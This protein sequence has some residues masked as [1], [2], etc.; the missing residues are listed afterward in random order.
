MENKKKDNLEQIASPSSL[1]GAD[2]GCRTSLR[3]K[4][5][6]SRIAPLV[7]EKILPKVIRWIKDGGGDD[8]QETVRG[9]LLRVVD[10]FRDGYQTARRLDEACHWDCDGNLAEILNDVSWNWSD[11]H[12]SLVKSWVDENSITVSLPIGTPVVLTVRNE[13]YQGFIS[14]AYAETAEYSVRIPALGHVQ[15]GCGT[16]GLIVACE[17]IQTASTPDPTESPKTQGNIQVN[18]EGVK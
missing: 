8:D 18:P 1:G 13:K 6:D 11:A 2:S 3:P 17:E 12:K 14:E 16:H 7:V 10:G 4:R 9:D 15:S 5:S